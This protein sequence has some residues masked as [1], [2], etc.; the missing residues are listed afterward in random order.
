M[1]WRRM[2][3]LLFPALLVAPLSGP[4]NAQT[5]PTVRYTIE[6]IPAGPSAR[7]LGT[8][9]N[10]TVVGVRTRTV[11]RPPII[12][13]S[14]TRDRALSYFD[15]DNGYTNR[16]MIDLIG[17]AFLLAN[18]RIITDFYGA[19]GE[20]MRSR[21][22]RRSGVAL[23][24][25]VPAV[26]PF[27]FETEGAIGLRTPLRLP[28]EG[29]GTNPADLGEAVSVSNAGWIAGRGRFSG[30]DERQ[31]ALL[32]RPDSRQWIDLGRSVPYGG[33][34]AAFGVNDRGIV[35]GE[36]EIARGIRQ[37]YLWDANHR[38]GKAMPGRELGTL[39]GA[40]SRACAI[41]AGGSVAGWAEN[42]AFEVRACLW[43]NGTVRELDTPP[44]AKAALA[45]TL[46]DLGHSAGYLVT[47][48][49]SFRP[50]L[51]DARGRSVVLPCPEPNGMVRAIDNRARMVGAFGRPGTD[52]RRAAF[53]EGRVCHDLNRQVDPA[54]GW[55][56][57]EA[58]GIDDRGRIV[59]WGWHGGTI[60]AFRLVPLPAGQ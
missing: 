29:T 31:H 28:P 17:L 33:E 55:R 15:R 19:K 49:G 16:Q 48:D 22:D 2:L 42:A 40:A 7:I 35:V 44:G 53:W 60:R 25:P 30:A 45:V 9:A 3:P 8:A 20:E 21:A 41:N 39:G 13:A 54:N 47:T 46:N 36:A 24:P 32:W 4:S 11:A 5:P 50:V 59:G 1:N 34:S 6:E 10:G 18:P 12:V 38:N 27:V 26:E 58:T 14:R 43:E 57:V 23:V 52:E 56:L 37:A 51:W